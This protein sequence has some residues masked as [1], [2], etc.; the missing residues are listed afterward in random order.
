[1]ISTL[2]FIIFSGCYCLYQ[3]SKKA[4][5]KKQFGLDLWFQEN[6]TKTK[7]LASIFLLLTLIGSIMFFGITSGVLFWLFTVTLLFSLIIILYPLNIISLK[8]IIIL[9]AIS[10]VLELILNH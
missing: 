10:V 4:G 2:I 6:I 5:L 9:F 8:K 1:M 7:Y 3:T